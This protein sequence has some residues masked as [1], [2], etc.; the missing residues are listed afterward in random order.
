MKKLILILTI[1]SSTF[2]Y[3][4]T[5]QCNGDTSCEYRVL[6]EKKDQQQQMEKE[7]AANFRQETLDVQE[8]QLEETRKQNELIQQQM[9]EMEDQQAQQK[10]SE[11]PIN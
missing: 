8:A 6:A 2:V 1:I 10:D 5:D 11:E 4:Q 7:E 9:Q 3:A